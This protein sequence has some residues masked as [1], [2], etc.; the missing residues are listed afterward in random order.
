MRLSI[1]VCTFNRAYALQPCLDSIAAAIA[2]APGSD[3]EIVVVNNNSTDDTKAVLEQWAGA[4]AIPVQLILEA[5]K[6]LAAARNCGIRAA[7]GDIIAFT[8]DDCRMRPAYVSDLLRHYAMDQE[9]VMRG[10]RIELG[11]PTD[12]PLTIKTD[13]EPMRWDRSAPAARHALMGGECIAG[14]NMAM[15]RAVIDKLGPF[16][17]KLGAGARIP[18]GEDTDY[19]LRAYLAGVPIVYV[20]DMVI[21]HWHGRKSPQQANRLVR[22]YSTANGALY[23]KYLFRAPSVCR[24]LYWDIRNALKEL[25]RGRNTYLPDW[26]F[27]A[28]DKVRY[29]VLGMMKYCYHSIVR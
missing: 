3:A 21:D 10:G 1:I 16:D 5:K 14:C 7:R 29:A 13:L 26:K 19:F 11:D 23:A 15:P 4:C 2:A 24:G 8:D 20:P 28:R 17:E 9:A 22:N 18:G 27:S 12:L 6:G 25:F